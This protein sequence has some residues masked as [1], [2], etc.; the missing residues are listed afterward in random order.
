MIEARVIHEGQRGLGGR[1]VEDLNLQS[2]GKARCFAR[3]D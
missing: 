2:P 1:V 3:L